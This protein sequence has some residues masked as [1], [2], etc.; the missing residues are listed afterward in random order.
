MLL[1]MEIPMP[2]LVQAVELGHASGARVI[3]NP[4]PA[5]FVPD[6]VLSRL[7]MITPNRAEAEKLTGIK[8]TDMESAG[9]AARM[10]ADKG[11]GRVVITLGGKGSSSAMRRRSI[12]FRPR[13]VEAVDTTAAGDTFNG[14]LCVALSEGRTLFDAVR[15]ASRAAA[16]AVTRMGAQ[17]SIPYRRELKVESV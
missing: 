15:F 3:L 11:I 17:T 2:A 4:A 13:R 1:Q 16:I 9:R 14:A 8:V 12:A 6:S 7:Y 5:Q 10:L